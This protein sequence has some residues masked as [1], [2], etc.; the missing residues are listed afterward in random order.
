MEEGRFWICVSPT[1]DSL[2]F[3]LQLV[4]TMGK[5]K[6]ELLKLKLELHT[7]KRELLLSENGLTS[8]GRLGFFLPKLSVDF[9]GRGVGLFGAGGAAAIGDVFL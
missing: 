8:F 7:L 9:D 5:L 1:S 6:L 3:K 4:F 2:E